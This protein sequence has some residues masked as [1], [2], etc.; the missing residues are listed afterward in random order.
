M[1]SQ[2]VKGVPFYARSIKF[3]G[4]RIPAKQ[5]EGGEKGEAFNQV[6]RTK[7]NP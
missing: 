3:C 2:N 7:G 4:K 5:I 6:D 1:V